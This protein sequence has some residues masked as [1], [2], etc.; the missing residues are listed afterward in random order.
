VNSNEVDL[1]FVEILMSTDPLDPNPAV[2]GTSADKTTS[3]I[4]NNTTGITDD[5][6]FWLRSVDTFG[7]RSVTTFAGDTVPGQTAG[8]VSMS[9][10]GGTITGPTEITLDCATTPTALIH[11]RNDA[12]Q[13]T[14]SD[15][16]Y[17]PAS[18]PVVSA[19]GDFSARAFLSGVGGNTNTKTFTLDA[20][21]CAA[22]TLTPAGGTYATSDGT[23]R[24]TPASATAGAQFYY[25]I[26]DPTDATVV[27]TANGTLATGD[28]TMPTGTKRLKI[29]A[30][31]IGLSASSQTVADYIVMVSGGGGGGTK[32]ETPLMIP[33]SDIYHVAGLTGGRKMAFCTKTP[34]ASLRSTTDNS[35]PTSGTGGHGV[36]VF[37]YGIALVYKPSVRVR[38][39]AYR[40]GLDDSTELDRTIS[41]DNAFPAG[42]AK[43]PVPEFLPGDGYSVKWSDLKR[44]VRFV[45]GAG[46]PTEIDSRI[47]Q[48]A[49]A[50]EWA[51]G[52]LRYTL[53]GS[54]PVG[55]AG[56]V[57]NVNAGILSVEYIEGDALPM[58]ITVK[59][60]A[61]DPT[62]NYAASDV[63]TFVMQITA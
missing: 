29:I 33:V 22:P 50:T 54:S 37:E 47:L 63:A 61:H 5:M 20:G 16:V 21:A 27:T 30:T 7:N 51:P 3:F 49:L 10:D 17:D 35:Q 15:P 26:V 28:I 2:I 39:I 14:E 1:D 53:D 25:R 23:Q 58:T 6:N 59:A 60:L 24:V 38:V 19:S 41:F 4:F 36:E 62:N 9:P 12:T 42:W 52:N 48:F 31:K 57:L 46:D 18:K 56:I 13:P 34:Q 44:R 55:G 32:V 40:N 43:L 8:D 45:G 11:Y